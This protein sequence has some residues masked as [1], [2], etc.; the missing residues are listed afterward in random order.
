M[1]KLR[2]VRNGQAMI[3]VMKK[4]FGSTDM[5][6]RWQK[7]L[8]PFV[9]SADTGL[10]PAT[11]IQKSI[12]SGKY[13]GWTRDTE[14]LITQLVGGKQATVETCM[15]MDTP[16]ERLVGSSA[17]RAGIQTMM[18]SA[19]ASPI[20]RPSGCLA[21]YLCR[22]Q[23]I[24]ELPEP[25]AGH[26]ALGMKYRAAKDRFIR[27]VV[28]SV[29]NNIAILEP[30]SLN[31]SWSILL[32]YMHDGIYWNQKFPAQSRL[33]VRML[34]PLVAVLD[35]YMDAVMASDTQA[36]NVMA[37]WLRIFSVALPIGRLSNRQNVWVFCGS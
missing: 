20:D 11:A 3:R 18:V 33:E 27:N 28:N 30:C 23:P 29:L 14:K 26:Q 31:S 24:S 1:G 25:L 36:I 5:L 6:E 8:V 37:A 7:P 10:Y 21:Y 2:N 22:N 9:Q 4:S 16:I 35:C 32:S 17:V 15:R 19:T 12:A 34:M 13:A